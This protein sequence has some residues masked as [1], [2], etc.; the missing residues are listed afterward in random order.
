MA[1]ATETETSLRQCPTRIDGAAVRIAQHIPQGLC[2]DRQRGLYHKCFLCEHA[3]GRVLQGDVEAAARAVT[4]GAVQPVAL[5]WRA[6]GNG[7]PANGTN[8]TAS[9]GHNG[10]APR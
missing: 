8:G 4:R 2:Q 7:P 10:G 1:D 9:H 6:H 3:N 5:H